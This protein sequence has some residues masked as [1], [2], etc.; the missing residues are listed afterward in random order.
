VHVASHDLRHDY[1]VR[2]LAH[3]K[4]DSIE[5]AWASILTLFLAVGCWSILFRPASFS[6]PIWELAFNSVLTLFVW[7]W[8]FCIATFIGI[9]SVVTR[10]DLMYIALV[11]AFTMIWL[12]LSASAVLMYYRGIPISPVGVETAVF[13]I[14]AVFYVEWARYKKGC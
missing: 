7:Q 3:T 8:F 2:E 6:S 14:V 11:V 5:R 10:L 1:K 9:V 12:G 4:I 13:P